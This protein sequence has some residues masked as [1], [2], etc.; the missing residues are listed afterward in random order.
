MQHQRTGRLALACACGWVAQAAGEVAVFIQLGHKLAAA[1][2]AL[3]AG[4]HACVHKL[5]QAPGAGERQQRLDLGGGHLLVVQAVGLGQ[6]FHR[7]QI[8][9]LG[10][11]FVDVQE[12]RAVDV[13]L[14]G[15][16]PVGRE[17]QLAFGGR[18][19]C[20]F[21]VQA[22]QALVRQSG[23]RLQ[24]LHA[25]S[26]LDEHGS[27]FDLLGF[28]Q[29]AFGDGG[30]GGHGRL[31]RNCRV[32]GR[33]ARSGCGLQHFRHATCHQDVGVQGVGGFVAHFL[34]RVVGQ[35]APHQVVVHAEA[36]Q[37]RVA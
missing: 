17:G 2:A 15:Q 35:Q 8:H 28:I 6:Q 29:H 20:N 5:H 19:A 10:Q 33:R 4:E 24:H 27:A 25:G 36:A 26:H 11:V 37:Q 1:L 16:E 32:R 3:G 13:F 34:G 31:S 7:I 22:D 12:Q 18:L 23:F 9:A 14:P 21:L 30:S